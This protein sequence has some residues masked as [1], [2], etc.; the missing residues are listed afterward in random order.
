MSKRH[1]LILGCFLGGISSFFIISGSLNIWLGA[2]ISIA[3]VTVVL[4]FTKKEA[5]RIQ[6]KREPELGDD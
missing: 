5:T 6:D 2:L 4:V 1:F 3:A